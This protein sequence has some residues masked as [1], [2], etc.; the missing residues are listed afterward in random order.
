MDLV[1]DEMLKHKLVVEAMIFA[2]LF[3]SVVQIS[4]VG[5]SASSRFSGIVYA[6]TGVPIANA[7]VVA[8]GPAGSGYATTSSSGQY[9]IDKGIPTGTYTVSVIEEGYLD[10]QVE[11]VQVTVGSET[12]GI[13]LYLSVSGG[14]SGKV[15]DAVSGFPLSNIAVYAFA[16]SGSFGW[17]GSTDSNGNYN[18]F[19]NLATGTYNVSAF[20][21]EGYSMKSA[22]ATVTAGVQTT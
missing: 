16:A 9:T 11:N 12:T 3:A 22:T 17:Y 19:T 8:S 4:A 18:I 5:V 2:I 10:A 13:N 7:V 20:M 1:E 6:A 14:I 15:T 21:P